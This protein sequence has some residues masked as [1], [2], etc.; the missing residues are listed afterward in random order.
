MNVWPYTTRRWERLRLLKLQQNP[1]CEVC[2][3]QRAEVV[4][5]EVV[6]HRIPISE[7]GR[8]ERLASEA[9]PSLD[10]LASLCASHHN[11]KTRA[12]QLGETH[13]MRKGCDIFGCP[14]DP[15]HHWNSRPPSRPK[16]SKNRRRNAT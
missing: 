11:Q 1:L 2:L 14:N 9:F 4:A 6:D 7:R 8:K 16:V 3:Q 13:W 12:E 15:D 10:A 5:A